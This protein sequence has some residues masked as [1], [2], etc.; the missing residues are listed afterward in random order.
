MTIFD[1]HTDLAHRI[2]FIFSLFMRLTL[3][4]A[5]VWAIINQNWFVLFT[6]SFTFIL[7]FLPAILQRNY[8]L[9]LP[10]ELEI[11]VVFFVYAA[12]FLGEIRGF[13]TRYWWWDLF[14]HT[15]SGIVL[16]FIGFFILY[17][18]YDE[19]KVKASPVI[20][21]MFSFCFAVALG[22]LWEIFEF[23]MDSF[24]GVNMQKSGLVDTMSD[25]IVDAIG[26][27][28]TAILGYFYIKTGKTNLLGILIT[29]FI[30]KNPQFFRGGK[31]I[32][33]IK[34]ET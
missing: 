28:T 1:R 32:Q 18:L 11:I 33:G 29:H 13:Y 24:W 23:T 14:L 6:S 16:G 25:L 22:T 4:G 9:Y 7:T 30:R 10:A 12:L 8:Q 21:A 3:V 17:V 20:I 34:V 26:A 2:Q 15:T 31:A 5:F 27:L 19:E